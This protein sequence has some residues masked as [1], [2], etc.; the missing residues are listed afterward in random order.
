MLP[1]PEC[2]HEL[3]GRLWRAILK[4]RMECRSFPIV[5]SLQ[6]EKGWLLLRAVPPHHP[7]HIDLSSKETLNR[8]QEHGSEVAAL[9]PHT[10]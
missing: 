10:F 2:T 6:Q 5:E 7:Q 1:T 8:V 4:S 3:N 9:C